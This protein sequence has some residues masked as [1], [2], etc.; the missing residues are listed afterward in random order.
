MRITTDSK[1]VAFKSEGDA[2]GGEEAAA[3]GTE[4]DARHTLSASSQRA[5][6][7]SH[8]PAAHDGTRRHILDD[9]RWLLVRCAQLY[10]FGVL[11]IR[12]AS[13]GLRARTGAR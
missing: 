7:P 2:Q 8:D 4:L 1:A 11:D 13:V 10:F 3:R 9:R 6:P 12:R 5:R